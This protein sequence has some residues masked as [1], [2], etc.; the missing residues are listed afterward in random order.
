MSPL[1][2]RIKWMYIASYQPSPY[3]PS[4]NATTKL[5]NQ[6]PD[7]L[8]GPPAPEIRLHLLLQLP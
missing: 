5:W 7:K 8:A 2:G 1:I 6:V 4:P 3:E